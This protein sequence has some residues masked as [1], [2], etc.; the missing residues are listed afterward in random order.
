MQSSSGLWRFLILA[1]ACA[2]VGCGG[3][4]EPDDMIKIS[5]VSTG[6][7][8]QRDV[9]MVPDLDGANVEVWEYKEPVDLRTKKR[10]AKPVPPTRTAR[11]TKADWI[12]LWK[13]FPKGHVWTLTDQKA[14]GTG[15]LP[16][17]TVEIKNNGRHVKA[18]IEGPEQAS[19]KTA[20]Q[21]IEPCLKL[22]GV[23]K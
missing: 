13:G 12:A 6:E 1:L 3:K 20:W 21:I 10:D 5:M 17:Y 8:G 16:I 15:S 7:P 2:V 9:L 4:K 22:A 14:S 11:V 19:D 18:T 23:G